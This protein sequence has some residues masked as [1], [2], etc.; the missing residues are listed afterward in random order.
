M[1]LYRFAD[2]TV[3]IPS[4]SPFA[5][6]FF[7]DY[8]VQAA[9]FDEEIVLTDADIEN[10]ASFAAS[11][12]EILE[13]TAVLRRFSAILLAR[14]DGCMLHAATVVHNGKA[15]AFVAPS[16]T[17]KTTQC[18][19]WCDV[20]G[21]DTRILN[22][23][24]L[25][26]RKQGDRILAYGNPWRGKEHYGENGCYPLGGIYLL[27]RATVNSRCA[28]QPKDALG[29]LL[30][31]VAVSKDGQARMRLLALL[32]DVLTCVPIYDLYA[33]RQPDAVYTALG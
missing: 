7:E 1:P 14:Y 9:S 21:E 24:K 11:P 26:I 33:N 17:G 28:V 6:A 22:G 19:L 27:H 18:R 3:H 30:S 12:R 4:V 31:A 25:L 10:E 5:A 32:A 8:R 29:A 16:G 2:V 15:Y 13:I 20:F 23:D